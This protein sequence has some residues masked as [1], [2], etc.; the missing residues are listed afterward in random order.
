MMH[1]APARFNEFRV[2]DAPEQISAAIESG[3]LNLAE[4]LAHTVKGVAGNIGLGQVFV[5]A[6]KLEKAINC[7]DAVDPALLDEF[8][9]TLCRQ[10]Q[11]I[12]QAMQ[13]IVP[14][15]SPIEANGVDFD[16]QAASAALARLR[17]LLASSDGDAV[18]VFLAVENLLAGTIERTELE[19]LRKAISEFDF[20][21]ALSNLDELAKNT[22]LTK[23]T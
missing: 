4:R 22:A 6:G 23:M 16:K 1:L 11:A 18:E 9:Q 8:A 5:A 10:V 14:D 13:E 19:A 2:A 21:A 3:N 7:G 17:I 15:Q 20:D 12:R